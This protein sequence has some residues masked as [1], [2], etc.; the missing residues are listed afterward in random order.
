[1][2]RESRADLCLCSVL[3]GFGWEDSV[4]GDTHLLGAGITCL[5]D[6]AD[7]LAGT[8]A[9]GAPAHGFFLSS[10]RPHILVV[11]LPGSSGIHR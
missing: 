7:C 11:E 6:D 5:G 4:A 10:E 2:L 8:L 1:M 3:W 9:P